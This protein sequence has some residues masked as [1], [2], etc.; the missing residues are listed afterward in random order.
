M[1]TSTIEEV[2]GTIIGLDFG[3][4]RTGVARV[5]TFVGMPE[6]LDAIETKKT[7]IFQ[8]IQDVVGHYDAVAIVIGLPRGLDGQE[9]EQTAIV[10]DFTSN[11]KHLITIPVYLI[12]EAGTTQ[13][14]KD[15]L[16]N[17][18]ATSIDSMAAAILLE[19][20]LQYKDKK[21]LLA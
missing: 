11:L 12:D 17:R 21:Q 7:G 10:R 16:S 8:A 20:F 9:T 18:D 15:R 1:T 5:S 13:E 4:Q 19:D 14:A 3:G 2:T 6:P